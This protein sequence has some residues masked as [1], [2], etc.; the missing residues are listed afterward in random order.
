MFH[1]QESICLAVGGYRAT[2]AAD[3]GGRITSLEWRGAGTEGARPRPLLVSWDGETFDEHA[4]PKAGMFPMVPFSNQMAPSGFM[5]KGRHVKPETGPNGLALH[6]MGHRHPWKVIFAKAD[7]V[8]LQYAHQ[9]AGENAWPWSFTCHQQVNLSSSGLRVALSIRNES[10]EVMPAGLGLHPYHPAPR[11]WSRGSLAFDAA[12][13]HELAAHGQAQAAGGPPHFGMHAGETAA[14]SGWTGTYQLAVGGGLIEGSVAGT[15]RLVVHR[16]AEG[17]Y[18]CV[19][20]VT[21]LPG[22][23]AQAELDPQACL[24]PGESRSL[25]WTCTFTPGDGP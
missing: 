3:A 12:H 20:P 16:P 18:L 24:S 2:V 14:F 7:E 23:L 19:E 21:L 9:A 6:G 25:T 4:W 17:S 5:F 13:R 10:T 22:A 1:G 11:E 8:L 15:H